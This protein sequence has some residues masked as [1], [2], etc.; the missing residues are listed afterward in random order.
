MSTRIK[1][2]HI[3]LSPEAL[4]NADML[5]KRANCQTR[6]EFI[7]K[8]IQFYSGY[9]TTQTNEDYIPN[10]MLSTLKAIV[11]ESDN[12]QNRNLFKI[13]VELGMLSN[14][15]ATLKGVTDIN[16][17]RLRGKCTAEVKKLNGT[18]RIEDAVEWQNS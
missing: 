6:S 14:L 8:A 15:I 5:Q 18:L 10:I 2:V 3:R 17:E 9:L 12:R 7:D 13:A 1:E 16:M 11:N 4:A